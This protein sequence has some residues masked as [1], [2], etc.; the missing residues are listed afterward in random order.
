VTG[1]G[2][3]VNLRALSRDVEKIPMRGMIAA[4]KLAKKIA[5][6]EGTRVAG[7][8]GL[9]GKKKRGLKLRARDTIR[10]TGDGATCRVQGTVP[11]WVWATSGTD[12]HRIRR[13][14]KGPMRKMT[15]QHPG[16][17]G[18]GAWFRV[19]A[20][21]GTVVPELFADELAKVVR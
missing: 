12:P 21:V 17:R 19:V 8:D 11:G 2:A 18:K 6:E 16:S 9:K 14:K 7:A 15:V 13:R 4:A 5:L 20:R 1:V 10:D 3:S